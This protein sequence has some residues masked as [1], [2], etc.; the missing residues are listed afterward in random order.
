MKV[1]MSLDF[2]AAKKKKKYMQDL[3]AT[4]MWKYE[5][6]LLERA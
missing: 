1:L 3:I 2:H 6:I 4:I 5:K